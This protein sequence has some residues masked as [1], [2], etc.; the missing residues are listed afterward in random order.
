MRVGLISE[1][2]YSVGATKELATSGKRALQAWCTVRP[3]GAVAS[4][5][6]CNLREPSMIGPEGRDRRDA[7]RAAVVVSATCLGQY[8]SKSRADHFLWWVR[9]LNFDRLQLF[10][11]P[12]PRAR[13]SHAICGPAMRQCRPP[14]CWGAKH[15]SNLKSVSYNLS[16]GRNDLGYINMTVD[17]LRH[18]VYH[19]HINTRRNHSREGKRE[20]EGGKG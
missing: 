14:A 10:W 5:L 20:R 2:Y 18:Y 17:W 8:Y 4:A 12:E 9:E 19:V 13:T 7:I 6:P 16:E 3:Y 11:M 15:S 1:H